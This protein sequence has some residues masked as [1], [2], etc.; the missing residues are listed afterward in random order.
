M[1]KHSRIDRRIFVSAVA[2]V[3][4]VAAV[5][6]AAAQEAKQTVSQL[7]SHVASLNFAISNLDGS[8]LLSDQV[9]TIQS[10]IAA[11]HSSLTQD[12]IENPGAI[13]S[14]KGILPVS[15]TNQQ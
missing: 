2:Y 4:V 12:R 9:R 1:I 14:R 11:K 3:G 7:P 10:R 15:E 6:V 5:G 8:A 13:S